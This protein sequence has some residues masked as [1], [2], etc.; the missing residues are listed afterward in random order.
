MGFFRGV[1]TAFSVKNT[2]KHYMC[3]VPNFDTTIINY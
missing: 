3:V 1:I 2:K